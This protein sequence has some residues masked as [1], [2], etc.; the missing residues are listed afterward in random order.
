VVADVGLR[1]GG[2]DDAGSG[3]LAGEV[4]EVG[5]FLLFD[6]NEVLVAEGPEYSVGSRVTVFV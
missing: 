3:N 6:L 2:I 4:D 5:D 1:A